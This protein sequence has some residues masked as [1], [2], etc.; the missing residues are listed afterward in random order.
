MPTDPHAVRHTPATAPRQRWAPSTPLVL[1]GCLIIAHLQGLMS[2]T[3]TAQSLEGLRGKGLRIP[4]YDG[5]NRLESLLSIQEAER[6]ALTSHLKGVTWIAF[7]H[8]NTLR[9]TNVVMKAADCVLDNKSQNFRSQDQVEMEFSSGD[10][11]LQGRGFELSQTNGSVVISNEVRSVLKAPRQGLIPGPQPSGTSFATSAPPARYWVGS[12][13]FRFDMRD[14]QAIYQGDVHLTDREGFDLRS[15]WLMAMVNAS[16]NGLDAI[17]ARTNLAASIIASGQTNLVEGQRGSY[18]FAK[19]PSDDEIEITQQARWQMPK[20]DGSA[21]LLQLKPKQNRFRATGN[22]R[23]I[24][25]DPRDALQ[26]LKL[27]FGNEPNPTAARDPNNP[28]VMT[29][30]SGEFQPRQLLLTNHVKV[31]QTGRLRLESEGLQAVLSAQN[32]L[33]A[34]HGRGLV[35]FEVQERE[36]RLEGRA[37]NLDYWLRGERVEQLQLEGG[38]AWQTASYSGSGERIRIHLADRVYEATNQARAKILFPKKSAESAPKPTSKRQPLGFAGDSVEI[39]SGHYSLRPGLAEFVGT[40][41]VTN[42]E[43]QM[44]CAVLRFQLNTNNNQIEKVEAT[45]GVVF[46]HFQSTPPASDPKPAG[47]EAKRNYFASIADTDAAWTL[48]CEKMQLSVIPHQN[49]IR[50]IDALQRV[51]LQQ[52]GVKATGDQLSYNADSETLRLSG[53]P[54][55]IAPAKGE[56][57]GHAS[58]VLI[59]DIKSDTLKNE[60]V[61]EIQLPGATLIKPEAPPRPKP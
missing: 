49:Q 55:L 43:W 46:E 22:G 28:V 6:D 38:A 27:P 19:D 31:Q 30:G 35:R 40:V 18:R 2:P 23:A 7:S 61:V 3:L 56:F 29:F 5:Q 9:S 37:D 13:S 32:D 15:E 14:R 26:R 60:G 54:S 59:F 58:A 4:K 39:T 41:R 20:M 52:S 17:H 51:V 47:Q 16:T 53:T 24:L 11:Q 45:G 33:E 42:P 36:Q 57:R 8:T 12:R 48:T 10:L 21:D 1:L 50:Q 44:T 25:T 34:L